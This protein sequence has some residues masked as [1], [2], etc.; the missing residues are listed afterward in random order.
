MKVVI[1]CGGMGLRLR[2]HEEQLPKPMIPIGYRPMLWHV[3]RWYAHFGHTEFIL[4]LG[5]KADAIKEYFLSYNEALTND[6]VLEKGGREVT[7]LRSDIDNWRISFVDTGLT[8]NV[9]QRLKAVER[10]VGDDDVFLA[11]YADVLTDAHLPSMIDEF[12]RRDAIAQMMTVQPNYTFHLVDADDNGLVHH[13][14]DVKEADLW[15]NGGHF[16]FRREVFDFIEEGEELVREPFYRIMDLGRLSAYR[17]NGFWVP[18][19]T[20]KEKQALDDMYDRGVRPWCVW[21]D[22]PLAALDETP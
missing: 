20:I 17:H 4:C 22:E 21:E 11:N 8:A 13:M 7:L 5:Y 3:M 9:G 6:F 18:L 16:V 19:D 2:E 14:K 1:F 10:F 15:I 12:Y